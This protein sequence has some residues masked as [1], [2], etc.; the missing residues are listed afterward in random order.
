MDPTPAASRCAD[1]VDGHPPL[2]DPRPDSPLR[3]QAPPLGGL[4]FCYKRVANRGKPPV[5]SGDP[6]PGRRFGTKMVLTRG[7]PP[8]STDEP[9]SD[10]D[11]VFMAP[12]RP[13]QRSPPPPTRSSPRLKQQASGAAAFPSGKPRPAPKRREN[14]EPVIFYCIVT[15]FF[16]TYVHV[17]CIYLSCTQA[18]PK[19]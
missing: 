8:P 10:D 18:A 15:W 7:N 6:S 4:R 14:P 12:M 13:R 19:S 2:P 11:D 1:P 9:S 16:R 5:R 3:A 17:L